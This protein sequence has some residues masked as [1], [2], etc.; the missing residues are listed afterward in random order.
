MAHRSFS[1]IAPL[2][3][4]VF[5][6]GSCATGGLGDA[7]RVWCDD[8]AS[9]VVAAADTLSIGPE[10]KGAVDSPETLAQ[11]SFRRA[12]L[13]RDWVRACRAAYEGR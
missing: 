9:T 2:L 13:D 3:A 10:P 4:V 12:S 1:T 5:F 7:E 6:V 8:H 11:W